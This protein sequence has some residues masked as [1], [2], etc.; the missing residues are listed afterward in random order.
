MTTV[1]TSMKY[2]RFYNFPPVIFFNVNLFIFIQIVVL[3]I[4]V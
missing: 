1:C 2:F 3:K 4:A